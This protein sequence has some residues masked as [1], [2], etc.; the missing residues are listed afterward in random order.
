MIA[1]RLLQLSLDES[2]IRSSETPSVLHMVAYNPAGRV[3][4]WRFVRS[5]W[6]VLYD[7]SVAQLIHCIHMQNI[8]MNI[9]TSFS[10]LFYSVASLLFKTELL[11]TSFSPDLL[12]YFL[13]LVH[14]CYF[15]CYSSEW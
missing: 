11:L 1:F 9:R 4:T 10:C 8:T 14:F 6:K 5:H 2:V 15:S 3:L 12:C 13:F 7:R